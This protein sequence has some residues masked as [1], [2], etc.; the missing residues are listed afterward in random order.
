MQAAT[1]QR[2]RLE[3]LVSLQYYEEQ[4]LLVDGYTFVITGIPTLHDLQFRS[5]VASRGV[6]SSDL[7]AR[8]DSMTDSDEMHDLHDP[9]FFLLKILHPA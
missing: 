2:L 1:R 7:V 3:R 9:T 5:A 8:A 6:I 4:P